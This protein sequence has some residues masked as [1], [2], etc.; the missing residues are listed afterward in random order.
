M[1]TR[2]AKGFD[3]SS[4]APSPKHEPQP[5][6][7][8]GVRTEVTAGLANV[9]T[10]QIQGTIATIETAE[11]FADKAAVQIA[12]RARA[13][14]NGDRFSQTLLSELNQRCDAKGWTGF[15]APDFSDAEAA[16][17]SL[18]KRSLPPSPSKQRFLPSN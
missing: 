3:P 13:L 6:P 9:L 4:Q 10:H 1:A 14:L 17:E 11:Q 16:L 15:E 7:R 5:A 12:D 2:S 8:D 18:G